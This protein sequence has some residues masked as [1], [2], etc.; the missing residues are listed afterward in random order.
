MKYR[1]VPTV[2]DGYRLDSKAEAKRYGELRL[3]EQA[4]QIRGLTVHPRYPLEVND[5]L[6]CTYEADFSYTMNGN[7]VPVIEDVKGVKTP[8][9]RIKK[10]LF[11]AIHPGWKIT[12]VKVR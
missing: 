11:E 6:V 12:E 2:I 8:A 5:V 4:R 10:K 1:N 7:W 9:Y 3:L